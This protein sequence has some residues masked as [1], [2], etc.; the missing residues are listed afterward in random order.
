MRKLSKRSSDA[1]IDGVDRVT[2][3]WKDNGKIQ[4]KSEHPATTSATVF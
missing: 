4:G 3:W 2:G 1:V